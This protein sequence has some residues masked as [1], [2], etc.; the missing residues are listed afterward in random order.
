MSSRSFYNAEVPDFLRESPDA[1][2]GKITQR[3]SQEINH[4]QTGAWL[5][6]INLLQKCL[7]GLTEGFLLFEVLIPRMGKRA[8]VV[9]IYKDILFVLEFKVG[10]KDYHASDLRQ[11]HGYALDLHHFHEGSHDKCI[12]PMLIATNAKSKHDP[13]TCGAD[14][15]FEPLR[16]NQENV[17][18]MIEQC[19]RQIENPP[20]INVGEWLYASY[21]PTP[22]II[23]A[24]QALYANHDVND[25]A[26]ND[27]GAQNLHLTSKTLEDIIHN[28]RLH[29]RKTICFVT[30]VPGAGK[31]LVGLNIATDAGIEKEEQ[32]VFLSGN[33]PLVEVLTEALARD[34]VKRN[35]HKNKASALRAASA[36]IQN[37]HK[38]RDEY[39][40]DKSAPVEHVVIFD[41]AQRAW[42]QENTSKFMTTK[43]GQKDFAQSEPEFL[44]SV[45]DR[46]QDWCVIIALIGGGQEINTGE[47]GLQGWADALAQHFKHWDVFYSDKLTQIEYAGRDVKFD[48]VANAKAEPSLH[49]ATSMRSFRAEKLSHMVHHIIHNNPQAAA[50]IYQ[51]FKDKFPIVVT[52]DLQAAKAWIKERARANETK[53]VIASSGAVRL[54]PEGIFVKNRLSAADWFLNEQD[55]VRSC[56]YLE[57]VATEF[58]IQGLELDWCLVAWD[59]DYRYVNGQFEHWRFTGTTWKRRQQEEQQRYLENA[60]RVLL[61]RARQGMVIFVP[62]GDAEDNTRLPNFLGENFTYLLNCGV[63]SLSTVLE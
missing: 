30:G 3:H 26:R 8:D 10:A 24:A 32:A 22:T 27:A 58:D 46:H 41:E 38:F 53:G 48:A 37:I 19:V 43:R 44:I 35:A 5:S 15:V 12:V 39:I 55:D 62:L 18:A 40:K 1:I 20:T 47:A 2:I 4:E 25:I 21:K 49:L 45:M 34:S 7:A 14:L 29:Q 31:T 17:L 42:D 54:K 23:E 56:H 61:T 51:T 36:S 59:A 33:G 57:D 11:A 50:E 9:L 16:A 60:Y 52:R 63:W 13:I 28:A 6:Q